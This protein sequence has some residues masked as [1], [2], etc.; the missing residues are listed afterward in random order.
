M[1]IFTPEEIKAIVAAPMNVGMAVA[2]V[3]MG[4]VSTAIEAAAMSKAIVGAA[5]K[6]PHNSIIQAAFSDESLKKTKID[7]PEVQAD[8]VK[9]GAL[10]DQAIAQAHQVITMLQ[11]KATET[12][13]N[14]YKQFIYD[15]GDAVAH[16]SGSGLFGTGAKVS[17]A[18]A[19]TLERLKTSLGL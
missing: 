8:A 16:A 17:E 6:Y 11:G 19:A 18:E 4:I 3:D 5:Q 12:E 9:S 10:V 13:I 15:C 14:E 7:K 2:M 1:S